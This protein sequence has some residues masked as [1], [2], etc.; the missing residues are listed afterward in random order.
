MQNP[1]TTIS[2]YDKKTYFRK[3]SL[4]PSPTTFSGGCPTTTT[5]DFQIPILSCLCVRCVCVVF[6]TLTQY[7]RRTTPHKHIPIHTHQN[8]HKNTHRTTHTTYDHTQH[9]NTT[10]NIHTIQ[11]S[12][13]LKRNTHLT[14]IQIHNTTPHTQH[15][16]IFKK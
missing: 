4:P 9:R 14:H 7:T 2:V 11:H 6:W 8:T 10:H 16:N 12:H 15:T 1:S 5:P 13:T 3:K